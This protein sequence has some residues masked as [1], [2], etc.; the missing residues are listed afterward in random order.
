M[1]LC[2]DCK[3]AP[4]APG[5]DVCLSCLHKLHRIG[6]SPKQLR[7]MRDLLQAAFEEGGD[8]PW[9]IKA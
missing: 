1:K 4:A 7:A 3:D 9:V 6:M 5:R 2:D 8:K